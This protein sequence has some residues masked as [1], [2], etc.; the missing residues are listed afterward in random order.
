MKVDMSA[1]AVTRRLRQASELRDLCL[2]LA[3]PRRPPKP[4]EKPSEP[5]RPEYESPGW[6]PE[7]GGF[8]P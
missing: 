4:E 5:S 7:P 8:S 2:A 6:R 1:E 3:G